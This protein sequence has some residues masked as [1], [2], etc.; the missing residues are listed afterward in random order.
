MLK[1]VRKWKTNCLWKSEQETKEEV[2]ARKNI[3]R[4]HL[5]LECEDLDEGLEDHDE[6][7]SEHLAVNAVG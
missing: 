4:Q 7:M 1:D 3:C 5:V 2:K 6:A